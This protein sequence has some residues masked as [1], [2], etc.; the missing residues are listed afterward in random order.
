MK[1]RFKSKKTKKR[2]NVFI[3]F[4]IIFLIGIILGFS[5]L[6]NSTIKIK[7]KD[8]ADILLINS[9]SKKKKVINKKYLEKITKYLKTPINYL[10]NNYINLNTIPVVK[11]EDKQPVKLP[12]IYIYNSH[13]TEE[14][15][16]TTYAEFSVNPTVMMVDYILE[17]AFKKAGIFSIVEERSIKDILNNNNWNYSNSYRASRVYMEDVYEKN[18]S[19]KYFIDVHRDSLSRD[20]TTISINNKDYAKLIFLIGLENDNYKYNLDFTSKINNIIENKYPGLSKGIYK[21]GGV[22]VN[23]IYN[24]DFSKYTIL[25]EIGGYENNTTE[26]LNTTLAFFECFMEAI[27]EET[28]A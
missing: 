27:N 13:Q 12:L 24:Q 25:V 4:L 23:G 11:V 19:L 10:E 28:N 22:G 9:Y 7:D 20:K 1:K 18:K 26:V 8:Y 17:D 6:N 16:P 14:Y 2:K 3:F 5:Y 15:L 21:K